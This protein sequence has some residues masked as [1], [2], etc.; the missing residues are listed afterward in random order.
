MTMQ[1]ADRPD[2]A[3]CQVQD[4]MRIGD[5]PLAEQQ[6]HSLLHHHP[7]AHQA[8]HLLGLLAFRSGRLTH[9]AEWMGNAARLAPSVA[10]YQSDL[11]EIWRRLGNL[12]MAIACGEQ[13]IALTPDKPDAHYNLGLAYSD[14]ADLSRAG[15]CFRMALERDPRHDQAWNNLGSALERQGDTVTAAS[16]YAQA[17]ALA[18]GNAVAQYNLGMLQ[19][20]R[21]LTLPARHC[22][23]AA[24]AAQPDFAAA[25]QQ[26]QELL[27][28]GAQ[29][30][31]PADADEWHRHGI[32]CYEQTRIE[33]A[34]ACYQ[35]ALAREPER[36]DILNSLGFALQDLDS[37]DDA[38]DCFRHSVA[39]QPD[40]AMA[41]LNLAMAQL[42]LGDWEEGWANYEARWDS[43]ASDR[44]QQGIHRP[45]CPLPQWRGERHTRGDSLL[46]I[47]EQ[48]YGDAFQFSRYLT[49]AAGR[50]ARVG[51][52]CS[53]PTLRLME[54]SFNDRIVLMS[55]MPADFSGW[56]WQCPL[57]SLPLAFAT[58]PDTVPAQMPYLRVPPPAAGHWR[59]RLARAAP[60][61]L[62]IGIAWAGRKQHRCDAR[63]SLDPG[64]LLPLLSDPR[65]AWVSLQKRADGDSMPALPAGTHWLDWSD[66]LTDFADTA[67]LVSGLDLVISIDSVM[68]HLAGALDRPV[69]MLN[70]FDGEWRWLRRRDDSPWYPGLRLF[71]QPAF[72]DW[73]SVIG[74]VAQALDVWFRQH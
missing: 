29:A 18:P 24:L 9:A 34:I 73:N 49:L 14:A 22:F 43:V 28:S 32:A 19:R 37:M 35:Q 71:S 45:P 61:R 46:V 47:T 52:A 59:E 26:L 17:T 23:E 11:C 56:D 55:H 3:L 36:A 72:G 15:Q 50:F 2:E 65:F 60:D 64:L 30:D 68:V 16:A 10:S 69:W 70:R 27:T 25:R 42:K 1:L 4:T 40:F 57:M 67:A 6:C 41:R 48:G 74:Q 62:R 33:E 58:R 12:P 51:F 39:L 5:F 7:A 53:L 21:G 8:W 31:G 66:E 20:A 38:L 13:A 54:W 44:S 63:R